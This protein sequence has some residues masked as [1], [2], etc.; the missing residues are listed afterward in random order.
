MHAESSY[1]TKPPDPNPEPTAF[2]ESKSSGVSS[3]SGTSTVFEAPGRM[4]FTDRP[5]GGPPPMVWTRSRRE[6]PRGSSYRPGRPTSPE[7]VNTM[8]PGDL[9]VPNDRNQSAPFR[10]MCGTLDN[11]ST[12]LTTVGFGDPG[13]RKS[14]SMNGGTILGRGG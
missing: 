3:C 14:P 11:V 12:L 13:V 6:K 9:S 2:M 5:S 8:V 10:R 4:A 1:T 7:S